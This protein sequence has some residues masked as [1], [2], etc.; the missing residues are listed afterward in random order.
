MASALVIKV[1]CGDTLR[2]FNTN[3][4]ENGKLE[5]SMVQLRG[6]IRSLFSLNVNDD[7]TLTYIDTDGDTV[8]LVEDCDLDDVVSQRLNPV[9]MLVTLKTGDEGGY[10]NVRS[11]MNTTPMESPRLQQSIENIQADIEQVVKTVPKQPPRGVLLKLTRDFATSASAPVIAHSASKIGESFASQ[12]SQISAHNESNVQKKAS[13]GETC[14]GL[15]S[16]QSNK[17]AEIGKQK[18]SDKLL[19]VNPKAMDFGVCRVPDLNIA[20]SPPSRFAATMTASSVYSNNTEKGDTC[21]T[22]A[23]EQSSNLD[24]NP[25]N[26]C[27]F[28]GTQ[29]DAMFQ[30]PYKGNPSFHFRRNHNQFENVGEVFHTGIRCDECGVKPIT[31]PRFKSKVRYNYDLCSLCYQKSGNEAEFVRIDN[32][33]MHRHMKEALRLMQKHAGHGHQFQTHGFKPTASPHAPFTTQRFKPIAS[34]HAP[35]TINPV[36]VV[37]QVKL[38]NPSM[39]RHM[40]EALRLMQKHSGHGH[41]FQTHGFKPIASPHA[42][43]TTHGFKPIASPHAPFTINPV[44]VINQVK[45]DSRFISDVNVMD[46]TVMAPSVRFTKI[47]RMQNTGNVGWPMGTQLVWAGGDKFSNA[48]SVDLEIPAVGVP[49]NSELD[50]AV[51]FV[52]PELPGEYVSYWRMASPSGHRFGHRVWVV[53]QVDDLVDPL[54]LGGSFH[55]L[56]LNMPPQSNGHDDPIGIDMN[57]EPSMTSP[58]SPSNSSPVVAVSSNVVDEQ[59]K[60]VSQALDESVAEVV[61]QDQNLVSEVSTSETREYA[62]NELDLNFPINDTLLVGEEFPNTPAQPVV[63]SVSYPI[64][65]SS[66]IELGA[67]PKNV[68]NLAPLAQQE[69]S[70]GGFNEAPPLEVSECRMFGWDWMLDELEEM[71]FSDKKKNTK[72]LL[73]NKGSLKGVVMDLV[74]GERRQ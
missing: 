27:P 9:R 16:S 19:K 35:F 17:N 14:S 3:V 72:L 38:D 67:L 20:L 70:E 51:D 46:R 22:L 29:V 60:T 57:V 36:P 61:D 8:T 23:N 25:F 12:G 6:K 5:L 37:N 39:H 2:R 66:M 62:R 33:S 30:T 52:A 54:S 34:P 4:G 59:R 24:V 41:Q 45:L 47:W 10:L 53:I 69:F 50:V 68:D 58:H 42:P 74:S 63:S 15:S 48:L 11:S 13:E 55:Q 44:P 26:E 64:V 28:S 21:S 31:G 56:N 32:P 73:K 65:D 7:F 18:L 1:K 71:G 43:F 49:A 40:K